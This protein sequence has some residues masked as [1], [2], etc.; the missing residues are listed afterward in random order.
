M[1]TTQSRR[2]AMGKAQGTV[3]PKKSRTTGINGVNKEHNDD[4]EPFMADRL[5]QDVWEVFDPEEQLGSGEPEYGD[6]WL[7]PGEKE[8]P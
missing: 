1:S 4:L 8:E 7:E 2:R 6:F 5:P 3:A